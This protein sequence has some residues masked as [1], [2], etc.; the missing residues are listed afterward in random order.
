MK[1]HIAYSRLI[2]KLSN[3]LALLVNI[4]LNCQVVG[5]IITF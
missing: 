3:H 4:T 2:I 5:A 1:Q